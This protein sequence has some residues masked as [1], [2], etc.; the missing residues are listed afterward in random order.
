MS[1]L[2]LFARRDFVLRE[3]PTPTC[4]IRFKELYDEL[5][6]DEDRNRLICSD[7]VHA[8]R[9]GRAPIVLT[10]RNEHLDRLAANLASAIRHLIVLRGGMG[11]KDPGNSRKDGCDP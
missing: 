6:A 3:K 11:R 10:E 2:Y 7:V 1:T 5:I 8:T 9:E 4:G